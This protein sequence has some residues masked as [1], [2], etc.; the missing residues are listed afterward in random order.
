MPSRERA[1]CSLSDNESGFRRLAGL[2][3]SPVRLSLDARWFADWD[4]KRHAGQC[5]TESTRSR[6]FIRVQF[7]AAGTVKIERYEDQSVRL[8]RRLLGPR[9]FNRESRATGKRSS[10]LRPRLLVR[11]Y[12]GAAMAGEV[13]VPQSGDRVH[14]HIGRILV[15]KECGRKKLATIATRTVPM[16]LSFMADTTKD[17]RRQCRC[18]QH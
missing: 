13:E 2:G 12:R 7:A 8:D 17:S 16:P 1:S 3:E 10:A 11:L 4:V 18:G 15:V 14:C 6:R 9:G 5:L